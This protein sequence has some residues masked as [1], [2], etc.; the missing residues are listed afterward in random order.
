MLSSEIDLLLVESLESESE[1]ESSDEILMGSS[2]MLCNGCG[3]LLVVV[4]C[5]VAASSELF[6]SALGLSPEGVILIV[7]VL[8]VSLEDLVVDA[9]SA[10]VVVRAALLGLFPKSARGMRVVAE[11]SRRRRCGIHERRT[12]DKMPMAEAGDA[13]FG[14]TADDLSGIRQE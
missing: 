6:W 7:A 12:G 5:V 9:V 14:G 11:G 3:L 2:G 10:A 13:S 1:L 4:A 8:G